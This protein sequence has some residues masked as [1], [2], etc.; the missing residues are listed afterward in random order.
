MFDNVLYQSASEM[1]IKDISNGTLPNAVLFSGPDSAG[2]LTCA[3][4]LARVLSCRAS[5]EKKGYWLC[6]CPSCQR[7]K[8]L[9]TPDVIIAGPGDCTPEI[10]ASAETFLEA[11]S[12][13]AS[14]IK[15]AAYLFL[16]SVRKLTLR[17]S[18]VLWEGDDKAG[19]A[20][21]YLSAIEELLE[22]LNLEDISPD[23]PLMEPEKLQKTVDSIIKK[24]TALE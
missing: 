22:E 6:I 19:K 17:F 24:C 12:T 16:R 2:K 5:G 18:P 1:L 9:N 7:H 15:A 21:P 11:M 14:W 3:L 23:K 13:G 20:A 8:S 4:E 10:R